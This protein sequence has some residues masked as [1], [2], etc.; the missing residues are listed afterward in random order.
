MQIGEKVDNYRIIL[1]SKNHDYHKSI[2]KDIHF[3]ILNQLE[4]LEAAKAA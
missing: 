1:N 2:I 3:S 4:K